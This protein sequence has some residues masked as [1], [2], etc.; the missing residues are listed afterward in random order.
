MQVSGSDRSGVSAVQ[1]PF[2]QLVEAARLLDLV[3]AIAENEKLV[4]TRTSMASCFSAQQDS[5]DG[6][7][8]QLARTGS[9]VMR[10]KMA[11]GLTPHEH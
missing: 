2:L 3:K 10:G 5:G 6:R 1:W 7:Q 9:E 11:P 8:P 4:A